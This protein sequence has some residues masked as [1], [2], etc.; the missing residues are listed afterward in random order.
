ML[1]IN[2]PPTS[3][4]C[5]Y[6]TALLH[7][8]KLLCSRNIHLCVCWGHIQTRSGKKNPC[9]LNDFMAISPL[10]LLQQYKAREVRAEDHFGDQ[11]IKGRRLTPF[12]VCT[13]YHFISKAI[14][15]EGLVIPILHRRRMR[16]GMIPKLKLV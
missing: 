7:V 14:F 13:A 9:Y 1:L 15:K 8:F 3:L 4:C 2:F 10:C 16:L 12:F 11:G 5:F 6:T